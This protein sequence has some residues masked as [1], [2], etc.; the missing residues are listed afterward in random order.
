MFF[1]S[2]R[3]TSFSYINMNNHFRTLIE[4]IVRSNLMSNWSEYCNPL[5]MDWK[6]AEKTVKENSF[7]RGQICCL[8]SWWEG[9]KG[10]H[11]MHKM[12]T[13]VVNLTLVTLQILFWAESTLQRGKKKIDSHCQ[14]KM[15]DF[16][17]EGNARLDSEEKF[18]ICI[19]SFFLFGL[20]SLQ[21]SHHLNVTDPQYP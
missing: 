8:L 7:W 9:F 2:F 6:T 19:L 5:A 3:K 18:I 13:D 21:F 17:Q 4:W 1:P 12:M 15:I 20:A 14:M 16:Q 11:D 10:S